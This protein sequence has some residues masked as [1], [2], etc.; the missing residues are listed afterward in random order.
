M[1]PL[2]LKA[3]QSGLLFVSFMLFNMER[4]VHENKGLQPI[5]MFD[6]NS[7]HR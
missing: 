5:Y 7:L 6:V 4:L 3:G 2:D 1:L